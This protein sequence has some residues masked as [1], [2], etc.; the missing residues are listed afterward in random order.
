MQHRRNRPHSYRN[1]VGNS[2]LSV[3]SLL[4]S[5]GYKG[6]EVKVSKIPYRSW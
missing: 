1:N 2:V 6:V 3:E 5:E 4:K